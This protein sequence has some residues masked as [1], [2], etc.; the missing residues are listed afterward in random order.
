VKA[1]AAA[2]AVVLA[3]ALAAAASVG[4]HRSAS[5][6][7]VRSL[8]QTDS[9]VERFDASNLRPLGRATRLGLPGW[10]WSW[11][12]DRSRIAFAGERRGVG[13]SIVVLDAKTLRRVDGLSG[14]LRLEGVSGGLQTL[15]WVAP[16]RLLLLTWNEAGST[17]AQIVDVGTQITLGRVDL[18]GVLVAGA[19]TSRSFVALLAPTKGVGKARVVSIDRDLRVETQVLEGIRA[20]TEQGDGVEDPRL[21]TY[22]PALAVE[23]GGRRAVVVP[24]REPIADVDLEQGAVRYH[25]APLRTPS[26][27]AKVMNG[28]MLR[29]F[30][31]GNGSVG[32]TGTVFEGLDANNELQATPLGLQLLDLQ[33][34]QTRVA[35]PEVAWLSRAGSYLLWLQP[36]RGF[37]WY[38]L[39]GRRV[40]SL[41][42]TRQVADVASTRTRA[43]V[44]LVGES[45]VAVVDLGTGRILERHA[46]GWPGLML[47]TFLVTSST[48]VFG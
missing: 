7:G 40:G 12:P 15:V 4:A 35:D 37:S 36:E 34:W 42:A 25:A 16:D 5:V 11:S 6:V 29:G 30:W 45:R 9:V 19:P 31:L 20:G 13:W 27:V 39:A 18:K 21:A 22:Q 38:T 14:R 26:R 46:L 10:L 17:V 23:P 48:P 44:R 28:P 43:L 1:L 33:S 8:S 47:P 3:A 41:F 2:V 32:V 24:Y